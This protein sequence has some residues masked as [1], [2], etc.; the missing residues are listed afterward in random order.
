[1]R[2]LPVYV[3]AV[4]LLARSV[5][6]ATLC[7]G[8]GAEDRAKAEAGDFNLKVVYAEPG[9][10][11]IGGIR[12]EIVRDGAVVAQ[13][14]CPGPWF[15]TDLPAGRYE[16]R[17]VHEGKLETRSLSLPASGRREVTVVFR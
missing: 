3:L 17:A 12:T 14:D 8:V 7:S 6:A 13:G 1:M 9:G 2:Y 11:F 10:A 5:D 16:L 15:L 4:L